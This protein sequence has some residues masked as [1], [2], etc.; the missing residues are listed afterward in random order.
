M[1]AQQIIVAATQFIIDQNKAL[2]TRSNLSYVYERM[3]ELDS[4]VEPLVTRA[5]T[6]S[7]GPASA[8]SVDS[9]EAIVAIA[10]K[11]IARIKLNRYVF[12]LFPKV[13]PPA[14]SIALCQRED[15]VA[16]VLRLFRCAYLHGE[17]L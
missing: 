7:L 10:L 14:H 8:M 9:S 1:Q 5:D 16:P 12:A 17:T 13:V 2:Q 15:K 4:I 3:Q 11:G 6:W